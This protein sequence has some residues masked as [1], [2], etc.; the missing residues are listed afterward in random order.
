ML[1]IPNLRAALAAAALVVACAAAAAAP[2]SCLEPGNWSVPSDP[3]PRPI[4]P[5][6]LAATVRD[7][8]YVLLGETH[9]QV[10]DHRWQ[11]HALG[12]VLAARGRFVI[13]IE[14][15][16]REA[17]PVL[18][19]WVAGQLSESELLRDTQWNKVWGYD[20]ELYLPILHFARLHRLPLVALN[21]DRMLTREVRSRGWATIPPQQR[22]GVSDPAPPT[23]AYRALLRRWFDQHPE[24]MKNADP[25]AF[26]RFV[27]AQLTWDRAFAEGL[28]KAAAREP[29]TLVVGIIGSGHLRG[30]HGVP[31]QLAALGARQVRVW[32]P[33]LAAAPCT[34]L[35]AGIADAVFA[36]ERTQP[37][38][39][40][41]LGVLLE[42]DQDG[43]RVREVVA[44]GVAERAGMQRGDRLR[45]AAGNRIES[46]A[47]LIST[48]KRQPPGT[49]LPLT[50][51]R[52]GRELDLV[53]KFP[54][55]TQ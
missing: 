37:T 46:A 23:M 52:S 18:D 10:D 43:P 33:V 42:D 3:K 8:Q 20:A 31:H 34:E 16:P 2:Q 54:A 47:D 11:L 5:A 6:E 14:M 7:A 22:E 13:G 19:R 36:I 28:A 51:E 39:T 9:D 53:A 17:Q 44:G 41:R 21:V 30:G 50:V 48:V 25:G 12:M 55:A 26:D 15:L 49:W 38:V 1:L 24:P 4:G 27:E 32:L 40:P 45:A 35:G 29:G